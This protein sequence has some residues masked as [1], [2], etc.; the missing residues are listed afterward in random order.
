MQYNSCKKWGV[1]LTKVLKYGFLLLFA[2]LVL[3]GG[4]SLLHPEGDQSTSQRPTRV[5]STFQQPT[6]EDSDT[7]LVVLDPGHG[8]K[9]PGAMVGD[10]MEKD[11]TLAVALLVQEQ[12]EGEGIS[13]I[14]TRE[15]DVY[16]NLTERADLA[17]QEEADLYI[18]IHVNA[19]ENNDSYAGIYTFYHPDKPSDKALAEAIQAAVTSASGGIDR[20]VE[21]ED[22]AVLRNTEMS[23]VLIETG[24]MSCPEELIKL[25]DAEYQKLLAQGIAQGILDYLF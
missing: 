9:D 1:F 8:G 23:A 18:S 20:G 10:V 24:F 7:F 5:H 4:W 2:I 15:E 21:G 25:Q 22:Y 3:L 12:L 11:I 6:E 19:L 16:P 13:V 14:M 17:N